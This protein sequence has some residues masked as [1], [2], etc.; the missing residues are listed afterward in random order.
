MMR[1][2]VTACVVAMAGLFTV[3]LPATQPVSL[4]DVLARAA[5]YHAT[6]TRAVSGV[7]L[8]EQMQLMDVSGGQTRS[9]VRISS[10]V[11]L[12]NV[13][14][15]AIALRDPYAIDTRPLRERTP[16]ILNLLG[17]PA[18]PSRGDWA[19]ASAYPA[20]TT[21]Y[22]LLD[23]VVKVNQPTSALQ[24]ISAGQQPK[25]KYRLDGRR[26]LNGIDVVGVRFEEPEVRNMK[27]MLH[28][29]SN[30]R[31]T[32]RFWVDA[33]TGAIHQTELWVDGRSANLL[34][35]HAIVSVKYAP[36][37]ALGHLLPTEMTD[38]YEEFEGRETVFRR[39]VESRATYSNA[40]FAAIDLTRLR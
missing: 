1:T 30:A 25:L 16:R 24:F 28:T 5:A 4:P 36:H 29:R 40:T 26:K 3:G 11:V 23:V 9:I 10:D 14:G 32:G 17:A 7:Q 33:A 35:E 2:S 13:N 18:M 8:D 39:N 6:Y 12:V 20:A 27:Y 34:N 19:I 31:A 22:F 37:P 21:V 15:E 38:S